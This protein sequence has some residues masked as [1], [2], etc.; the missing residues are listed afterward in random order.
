MKRQAAA[1]THAALKEQ[2][3]LVL[4]RRCALVSKL[5]LVRRLLIIR[6]AVLQSKYHQ[7]A[8]PL[9]DHTQA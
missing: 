5:Q 6:R 3:R 7:L 8:P 4:A 9:F 1:T 2:R